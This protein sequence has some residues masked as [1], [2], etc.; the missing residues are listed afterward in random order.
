MSVQPVFDFNKM[1]DGSIYYRSKLARDMD[2]RPRFPHNPLH[3]MYVPIGHVPVDKLSCYS[4]TDEARELY[5]CFTPLT[6]AE[7]EANELLRQHYID[8]P[9]PHVFRP[10][11][12]TIPPLE[13]VVASV[14]AGSVTVVV[15][16]ELKAALDGRAS[17]SDVSLAAAAL[18]KAAKDTSKASFTPVG[19]S[20]SDKARD[21]LRIAAALAHMGRVAIGGDIHAHQTRKRARDE[22]YTRLFSL[23]EACLH[24]AVAE[25]EACRFTLAGPFD[26]FPREPHHDCA[27][28]CDCPVVLGR[29]EALLEMENPSVRGECV[30]AESD[31]V[32]VVVHPSLHSQIL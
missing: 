25:G 19:G 17:G 28:A 31:G 14:T 16:Q 3:I 24:N 29:P 32:G 11:P 8:M 7:K 26:P 30:H 5:P 18:H 10:I 2:S 27:P 20:A 15:R 21:E 9:I 6:D 1:L 23:P 12:Y 13:P 4:D 22:K